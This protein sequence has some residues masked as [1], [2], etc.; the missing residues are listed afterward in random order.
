M[1]VS[2]ALRLTLALNAAP[3]ASTSDEVLAATITAPDTAHHVTDPEGLLGLDPLAATPLERALSAC[4]RRTPTEHWLLA[5]PRSGQLSILRGP[6][7]VTRA[8]LEAE[9]VVLPASGGVAWVPWRVGP[10][11]QWQLLTA[12]PPAPGPTPSEADRLL[13]AAMAE[14]ADALEELGMTSGVRPD[15]SDLP[16]EGWADSRSQRSAERAWLVHQAATSGLADL[17]GMIHAHA[18]GVRERTLRT[19]QAAAADALVAAVNH[20]H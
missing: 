3:S 8:A 19:L 1:S 2:A 7:A 17:S 15:A 18:V 9:A 20:H 12:A 16:V 5:L 4:R 11:I 6:A 10:A 13:L 14:A